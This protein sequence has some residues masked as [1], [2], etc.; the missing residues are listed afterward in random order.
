[1]EQSQH[2]NN[3]L[4]YKWED[5]EMVLVLFGVAKAQKVPLFHGLGDVIGRQPYPQFFWRG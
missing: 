5:D 4:H 1:M 3:L 2:S